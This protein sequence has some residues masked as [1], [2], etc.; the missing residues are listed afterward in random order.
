MKNKFRAWD[1]V[2]KKMLSNKDLWDIP[3]NELFIHTPD[4]RAFNIMQ[5]TDQKVYVSEESHTEVELYEGDKIH[6]AIFDHNDTDTHYE[7]IV[8]WDEELSAFMLSA[9]NEYYYLGETLLQY[10][11]P[12]LI[13]NIHEEGN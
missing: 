7:G 11:E 2:G 3:Y 1:I 10:D 5:C 9:E 4:Q 6:F 13:G 8:V 12:F